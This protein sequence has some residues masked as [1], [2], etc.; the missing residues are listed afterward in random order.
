M[1]LSL[2]APPEE[3]TLSVLYA[4]AALVVVDKPA[5]LLSVPGRGA[6]KADCAVRRVQ[7]IYP[8][9]LTVHRL[10]MATSGLLVLGR[11]QAAQRALSQAFEARQVHKKYVAIVVGHVD[12]DT[13]QIN[14][15][16]IADWPNRPLQ[17]IDPV[18]GK[19]SL[20]HWQVISRD[21]LTNTTRVLLTPVTG[22]THQLRVHLLGL[23]HPLLGDALYAPAAVLAAAPRL[24]LHA[25]QLTLPHPHTAET[26]VLD[27]APPF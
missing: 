4:D 27:S 1:S 8:D 14:F 9:A 6:D 3:L 25:C 12:G 21:P 5:G 16:L 18:L 22:R 13:G 17:K 10:D 7:A 19:P 20:T 2:P 24:M 15:P 23:G 26:L 11:G